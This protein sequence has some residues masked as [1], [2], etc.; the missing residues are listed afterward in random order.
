[1]RELELTGLFCCMIANDAVLNP[2]SCLIPDRS[3]VFLVPCHDLLPCCV[4][5]DCHTRVDLQA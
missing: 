4:L 3:P 1:M 5:S 2:L